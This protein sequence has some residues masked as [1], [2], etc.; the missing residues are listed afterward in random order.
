MKIF[1]FYLLGIYILVKEQTESQRLK[2]ALFILDLHLMAAFILLSCLIFTLFP[3]LHDFFTDKK[4]FNIFGFVI[5]TLNFVSSIMLYDKLKT[6]ILREQAAYKHK[7][8]GLNKILIYGT[9]P[10]IIVAIILF[11]HLTSPT[12]IYLSPRNP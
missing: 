11:I 10:L 9:L 3:Q 4:T 5:I 2:V 12:G 6:I 7:I 1:K 8:V